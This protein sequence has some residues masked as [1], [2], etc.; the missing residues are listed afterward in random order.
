MK[1]LLL[2]L[3]VVSLFKTVSFSDDMQWNVSEG[4]MPAVQQSYLLHWSS[5]EI[6]F[7]S[8]TTYNVLIVV[9]PNVKVVNG[10]TWYS[11]LNGDTTSKLV[12]YK[13]KDLSAYTNQKFKFSVEVIAK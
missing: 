4:V 3:C 1:K 7:S 6:I 8:A 12:I 9:N 10:T 5:P 2:A 11:L 13:G